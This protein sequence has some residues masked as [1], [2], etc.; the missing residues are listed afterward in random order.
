MS[1]T[2][3]IIYPHKS[4]SLVY[5]QQKHT[6][7]TVQNNTLLTPA[8]MN[9]LILGA[10][11]R[12][13][14]VA[15]LL[16]APTAAYAAPDMA[17]DIAP[18][19]ISHEAPDEA[20]YETFYEAL[21]EVM[22]LFSDA[23]G[24]LL[25]GVSILL[26][27]QTLFMIGLQRSRVSHKRSKKD[28]KVTQHDLQER[29]TERTDRLRAI[30]NQLYNEIAKHEITE[31]LLRET[32]GYLH[33]IINS[34]PSIL[35]GITRQGFVTHWNRAAEQA[36]NITTTEAM[37]SHLKQIYPDLPLDDK[38]IAAAID[39]GTPQISENIQQGTGNNARYSDIAIYPL[40][41]SDVVG[42]V[43]RVDDVTMRVRIENMM[44]QNEK[45][46]SL[47]ELAAGMAHEINNPL[48]AIVHGVQNI[49]R[50]CTP[51]LDKND[52]TAA[53][54]GVDFKLVH[55]YLERREIFSFI[56]AIRDAGER[57]AKIVTNM[58]EFSRNSSREHG[59][60]NIIE[61]IE[62]SLN[63]AENTFELKL[64]DG[65]E[66]P[67]IIRE[68]EA[69]I[70]IVP[71]SAAEL[72]QVILN[73]LRNASQSFVSED[74]GPPLH[75]S[76]TLRLRTDSENLILDIEDNGPGMPESVMRHIFEPFFTT[77][78]VGQG[79]GLGL[80]VSYFIITEHHDGTIEVDSIPGKGT[81]F[82]IRLPLARD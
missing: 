69:N 79:T 81:L 61:L 6:D 22:T 46:M 39:H 63:L 47:G 7:I 12:L 72:Q 38:D 9:S 64:P 54:I 33:S 21:Y 44:I 37:G 17:P 73:L 55:E 13:L 66:Q 50:R 48:S 82:T 14:S 58:L 11:I 35:I 2:F 18:Y 24:T 23:T 57:S 68:F 49:T 40:L 42:A 5:N 25:I 15:V 59:L 62:H 51:G 74:Y 60:I 4:S 76:I 80:S 71:G 45:M 41:S 77:K 78:E 70:P 31:E 36:T 52:Q 19:E 34:M 27:M 32:Q 29:I 67:K 43:V 8:F 75:P 20:L 26:V 16:S 30:N 1:N 65:H 53:E 56:D 3:I 28:L 10:L